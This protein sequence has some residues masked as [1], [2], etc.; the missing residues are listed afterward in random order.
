MLTKLSPTLNLK[1]ET[2]NHVG[3]HMISSHVSRFKL[4]VG[5][6]LLLEVSRDSKTSCDRR[7][8]HNFAGLPM[9]AL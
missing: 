3:K 7:N 2:K 9:P 1:R 5:L 4:R 6:G 8:L